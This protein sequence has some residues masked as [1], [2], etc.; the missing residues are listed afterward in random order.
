MS[1][2]RV[3]A[4]GPVI[5]FAITTTAGPVRAQVAVGTG[6]GVGAGPWYGPGVGT[7]VWFGGAAPFGWRGPALPPVP[8]TFMG[9]LSTQD[10]Y[11][12]SY[13]PGTYDPWIYNP[14]P[15]LGVYGPSKDFPPIVPPAG[16][17]G[18]RIATRDVRNYYAWAK[19]NP[20]AAYARAYGEFARVTRRPAGPQLLQPCL[21]VLV[22]VPTPDCAVTIQ[23]QPVT[24]AGTERLFE[25]PA[26]TPGKEYQYTI[27]VRASDG[28]AETKTVTGKA[29]DT[30][31]LN[32]GDAAQQSQPQ[33]PPVPVPERSQP[34]APLSLSQPPVGAR[35]VGNAQPP[36][37]A[38]GSSAAGT[39]PAGR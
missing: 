35:P 4:V 28:T 5:L 36:A 22:R 37:Q 16:W 12:G 1:F 25:S 34:P 33:P 17:D 24:S 6:V 15:G 14:G 11:N 39:S 19:A 26:L 8:G 29:G 10:L 13:R 27:S 31:I 38:G 7:G 30:L 32:F 18:P 3:A 2:P 20:D 23:G 9:G 21:R